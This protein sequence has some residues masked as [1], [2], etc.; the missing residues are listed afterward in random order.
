MAHDYVVVFGGGW[1]RARQG[2]GHVVGAVVLG[3]VV[4]ARSSVASAWFW[5]TYLVRLSPYVSP[6]ARGFPSVVCRCGVYSVASGLKV[7]L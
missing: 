2:G 4:A 7:R 6:A 1:D 3:P 5:W